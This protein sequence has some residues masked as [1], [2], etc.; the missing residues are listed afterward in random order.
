MDTQ[1]E[2]FNEDLPPEHSYLG[3][4]LESV[5]GRVI[6]TEGS[7]VTLPLLP[8]S[9]GTLV[10]GQTFPMTVR[11]TGR[12]YLFRKCVETNHTFGCISNRYRSYRDDIGEGSYGTTAEIYEFSDD[13]GTVCIKAK[14]RQRFKLIKTK[15]NEGGLL[16]GELKILPEIN[17]NKPL[18]SIQCGSL[19]RVRT[20]RKE[21][22]YAWEAFLTPWPKWVYDQYD[23]D[24]LKDRVDKELRFL[25]QGLRKDKGKVIM[26]SDPTEL[27]FWLATHLDAEERYHVNKLDSPIQRIRW[28][29]SLMNKCQQYYCFGCQTQIGQQ[30]DVFAM[31]IEGAQGI[32]VNPEGYLHDTMTL[33]NATNL[34][35]I[36][37]PSTEFSWFPGYA[38]SIAVCANCHKHI[39]WQFIAQKPKLQPRKF[40]GLTRSSL[41]TKISRDNQQDCDLPVM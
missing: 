1:A 29:L 11:D 41:I 26:P 9:Y 16:I 32:Y 8:R 14:A 35:L 23:I 31:S 3:E 39:G 22:C 36:S 38:W 28:Q 24:K 21:K 12:S 40:Y 25:K 18:S 34:V 17:L 37:T 33:I 30:S 20:T 19:N 5:S 6:L 15:R 4:N 13:F 10:P 7:Y 2:T 27:S